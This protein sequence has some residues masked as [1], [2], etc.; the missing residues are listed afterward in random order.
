MR[1]SVRLSK[2][3]KA[4][5]EILERSSL[6]QSVCVF[7]DVPYCR[8][9]TPRTGRGFS[10]SCLFWTEKHE[11]ATEKYIFKDIYILSLYIDTFER[12]VAQR[13]IVH[14]VNSKDRV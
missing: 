9:P 14:C 1:S 7:D 12:A 2:L 5:Y 6:F 11:T 8:A 13:E 4:A 3:Q 10:I